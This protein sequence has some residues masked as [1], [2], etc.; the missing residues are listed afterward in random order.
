MQVV[1]VAEEGH[2]AVDGYEEEYA[3]DVSLLVGFKVMCRVHE[4]EEG[5]DDQ[6]Y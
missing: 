1:V 2:D 3:D 6:G 4:D 5:G